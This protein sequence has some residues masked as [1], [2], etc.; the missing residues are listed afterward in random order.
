[1]YAWHAYVLGKRRLEF[2]IL[3]DQRL[4]NFDKFYVRE[5]FF[6]ISIFDRNF[7]WMRNFCFWSR[8]FMCEIFL[9]F[10]GSIFCWKFR[11]LTEIL[12]FYEKFMFL[13]KIFRF[14]SKTFISDHKFTVQLW[15]F[16]SKIEIFDQKPKFL[17][18]IKI[19]VKNRNLC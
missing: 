2:K 9:F 14:S 19:S 10:E 18:E 15:K 7:F 16:S 13:I 5:L 11:F 4:E 12:I 8:M 17:I 1:M 3:Y 6:E